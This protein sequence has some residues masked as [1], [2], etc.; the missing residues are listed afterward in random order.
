MARSV[1]LCTQHKEVN[2]VHVWRACAPIS[3]RNENGVP[4][5]GVGRLCLLA[6]RILSMVPNSAAVERIFSLFGIV[7]SKLRNRLGA[8][9]ARKEVFLKV[10][11]AMRFG[12]PGKGQKRHWLDDDDDDDQPAAQAAPAPGDASDARAEPAQEHDRTFSAIVQEIIDELDQ[13]VESDQAPAAPPPRPDNAQARLLKHLFVF[14][15]EASPSNKGLRHYWA[16]AQRN[17]EREAAYNDE[18]HEA[19]QQAAADRAQAAQNQV[20]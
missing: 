15:D 1:D 19:L 2:L 18:H 7:H 20:D 10:G 5:S 9:K 13:E 8:D 16:I 11:T 12:R 17:L 6:A 3:S 4:A 14:P